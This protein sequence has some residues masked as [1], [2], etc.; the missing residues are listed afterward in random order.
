MPNLGFTLYLWRKNRGLTQTELARRSGITRAN[1]AAIETGAR[2]LKVETLKRIA[3][4]LDIRPGILADGIPPEENF[5]QTLT[6]ESLERIAEW[7]VR[8]SPWD[9]PRFELL[10]EEKQTA[11]LVRTLLKNRLKISAKRRRIN[12]RTAHEENLNYLKA[13]LYLGPENF[14]NLLSRIEKKLQAADSE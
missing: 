11:L 2:D 10:P 4:A 13:K 8:T 14:K 5:P 9:R 6:R 1:L 7:V 12:P 3:R